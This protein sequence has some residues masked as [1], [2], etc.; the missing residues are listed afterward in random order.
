MCGAKGIVTPTRSSV[1][2][3]DT[4]IGLEGD[5]SQCTHDDLRRLNTSLQGAGDDH[6]DRH[7]S[8]TLGQTRRLVAPRVVKA[9]ALGPSR[10]RPVGVQGGASVADQQT[11]RHERHCTATACT[12]PK[13]VIT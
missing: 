4:L 1:A 11:G 12:S 7:T 5:V 3:A 8:Q 9:D 6:T 10:K 2:F 13:F